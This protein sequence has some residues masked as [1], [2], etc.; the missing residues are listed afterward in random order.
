MTICRIQPWLLFPIILAVLPG[1]QQEVRAEAVFDNSVGKHTTPDKLTGKFDIPHTRGE[2][3][4]SNLFHS[5]KTFNVNT[6]ESAT[7]TGPPKIDNVISRVTGDGRSFINGPLRSEIESANLW[8]INPNGVLFGK[9]ASLDVD[10]SFHVTTADYL[11]LGKGGRFAA[12]DPRASSLTSAPP[13]AFGFMDRHVAPITVKGSPEGA[14]KVPE[15]DALSVVGGDIKIQG[16]KLSAPSGRVNLA[17]VASKGEVELKDNDLNTGSFKQLGDIRMSQQGVVSTSGE[18]GGAIFIR[19]E[20]FVAMDRS[21]VQANTL[22]DRD[23]KEIDVEVETLRLSGRAQITAG[24]AGTGDAGN[25][26]IKA[27]DIILSG[28]KE[29]FSSGFTAS[30]RGTAADSGDAGDITVV[31]DRLRLNGGAQ[32]ASGTFGTGEG[33]NLQIEARDIALSGQKEG[34]FPSGFLANSQGEIAGSGGAGNITVEAESLR[35]SDGAQITSSTF[36]PGNAG[37]L[38]IHAPEIHLTGQSEGV[39]SAFFVNSVGT[40]P[41]SGDAGDISVMADSLQLYEG[42]QIAS[43]TLGPGQAGDVRIQARDIFMTEFS[44]FLASSEGTIA[45]S[46]DAGDI[47]VTADRLRLDEGAQIVAVTAGP[48]RGG[49]LRIEARDITL[50]GQKEGFSSAFFAFSAAEV[51]DSGDA[52]D[53]LVVATDSLRLSGGAQIAV[54]TFGSGQSGNLR[55]DAGD[56]SLTGKNEGLESAFFASTLGSGAGGSIFINAQDVDVG[57]G[58]SIFADSTGI[59]PSGNIFIKALGELRLVNDGQISVATTLSDAGNINLNVGDLL[60]LRD[61][62]AITTSV[63]G[64]EGNGGNI[65]IDPTFVVLDDNSRIIAQAKEGSGGN[66]NITVDLLFQSPDSLIDASS[67]FGQSGTI[68]VNSPDTNILGGITMLPEAFFDAAAL[69]K[70][71]CAARAGGRSSLVLRGGSGQ[72]EPDAIYLPAYHLDIDTSYPA[73]LM[74]NDE[75]SLFNP[76]PLGGFGLQDLAWDCNSR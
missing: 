8:F 34:L 32:I 21:N 2:L 7:F 36:G 38:H 57:E 48:G 73:H 12:S 63:A 27:Q 74:K 61:N 28:R 71:R 47:S 9:S 16:G 5:F 67:E 11:R 49:N 56:I 59:G 13:E 51:E 39:P 75:R 31:A 41:D 64:G 46:G 6:G 14:I 55:I 58:A 23:G 3:K 4:G 70:Q 33:G 26:Q 44:A 65:T 72:I 66:I 29:G 54:A 37:S 52:G 10:G 20:Q 35:L 22:D 76:I 15:G 69:M 19:G 60:H 24:T 18:G 25:L 53:I 68:T 1:I 30:S 40:I 62:S 50:N 43:A 17:S 45:G 42:A